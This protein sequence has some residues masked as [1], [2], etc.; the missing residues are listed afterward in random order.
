M[1]AKNVS[2]EWSFIKTKRDNTF[3]TYKYLNLPDLHFYI[4]CNQQYRVNRGIYNTIDQWLY[5][6]GMVNIHNRR[7][8]LLAFLDSVKSELNEAH[9]SKFLKFGHGGLSKRLN[10]FIKDNG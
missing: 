1:K 5:E 3:K 9:Q 2:D 4:W 6:C 7:I 8:H 10:D